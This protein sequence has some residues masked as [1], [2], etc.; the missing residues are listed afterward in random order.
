MAK[1]FSISCDPLQYR[2][3]V[4]ICVFSKILK[5]MVRYILSHIFEHKKWVGFNILRVIFMKCLLTNM[6]K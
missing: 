6:A 4:E 2:N 3:G 1:R 5:A